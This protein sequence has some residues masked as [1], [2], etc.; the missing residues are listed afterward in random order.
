MNENIDLTKILKNCPIGTEFYSSVLNTVVY[1]GM[2]ERSSYRRRIFVSCN[3]TLYSFTSSGRLEPFSN[4]ECV[5]FPSK[6]QRDWNKFIAPW[7]KKEEEKEEKK[8][9]KFNPKTLK[10]S[11]MVLVRNTKKEEWDIEIFSH[12]DEDSVFSYVTSVSEYIYCIP[13]NE[14][15]MYLL[16]TKE[17]APEFYKY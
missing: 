11:D 8:E 4:G 2:G 5:L 1:E 17:E 12:I 10:P 6:E 13:Y 9:E 7:Y 16:Y 14:D 15:T 3:N